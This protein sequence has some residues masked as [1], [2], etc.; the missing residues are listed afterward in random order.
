MRRG[1]DGGLAGAEEWVGE[2]DAHCCCCGAGV[3]VHRGAA[4]EVED[5]K[6]LQEASTPDH[7]GE[8]IVYEG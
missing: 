5:T 3:D 4:C 8:G 2:I 7:V 1:S 6:L